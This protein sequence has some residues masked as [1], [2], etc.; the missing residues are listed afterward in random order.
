MYKTDWNE[1]TEVKHICSTPTSAEEQRLEMH[2]VM[3]TF[4]ECEPPF[5]LWKFS[6]LIV[7]RLDIPNTPRVGSTNRIN[8]TS[9]RKN[10]ETPS[11]SRVK[12]EPASSPPD[13]KTPYKP[14]DKP[15]GIVQ[16][17]SSTNLCIET[18]PYEELR[19]TIAKMLA[20]K[21]RFSMNTSQIQTHQLLR[22]LS[23]GLNS[24]PIR[25]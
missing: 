17:A 6:S 25:T 11:I 18:D 9:K 24:S 13:F 4:L 2:L 5:S 16:Y 21:S 20:T 8:G 22:M 15:N 23:L 19:S 1:K 3:V 14:G 7:V 10:F 12:V